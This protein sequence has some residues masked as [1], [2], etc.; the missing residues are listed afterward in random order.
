[1]GLKAYGGSGDSSLREYHS[2]GIQHKGVKTQKSPEASR[3]YTTM[4]KTPSFHDK[5]KGRKRTE[6]V[7]R[8]LWLSFRVSVWIKQ[9]HAA[10]CSV[11]G[12]DVD[13]QIRQ[14]SIWKR[15]K[16]FIVLLFCL[17]HSCSFTK[18]NILMDSVYQVLH[19]SGSQHLG[20]CSPPSSLCWNEV[21]M[22]LFHPHIL[23]VVSLYT[24]TTTPGETSI[25]KPKLICGKILLILVVKAFSHHSL[26]QL[27]CPSTETL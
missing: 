1:M 12:F 23:Y 20:I 11:G 13:Q 24:E 21:F 22:L 9:W 14:Y 4:Q 3:N 25:Q 27:C 8:G 18:A 17:S 10:F 26:H 5:G 19:Q 2:W 6:D 7:C 16:H 15:C